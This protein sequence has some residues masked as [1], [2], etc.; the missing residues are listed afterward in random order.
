[1][2]PVFYRQLIT[3]KPYNLEVTT[4]NIKIYNLVKPNPIKLIAH[5]K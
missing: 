5:K 3:Y 1:M 4:C 2:N